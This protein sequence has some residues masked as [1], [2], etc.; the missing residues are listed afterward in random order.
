MLENF[1]SLHDEEI[2]LKA[3]KSKFL[4]IFSILIILFLFLGEIII[5]ISKPELKS[6]ADWLFYNYLNYPCFLFIEGICIYYLYTYLNNNLYLSSKKIIFTCNKKIKYINPADVKKWNIILNN[7]NIQTKY[8]EKYSVAG[9][10][11]A[12]EF[13]NKFKELYKELL[14]EE[15]KIK[16]TI[17]VWAAMTLGILISHIIT[18]YIERIPAPQYKTAE[19]TYIS[20]VERIIKSNWH[21]KKYDKSARI[22]LSFVTK[23]DGTITD[24][25]IKQS[26]GN[27]DLDNTTIDAVKKSSPLPALPETLNKNGFITIEFTFDYNVNNSI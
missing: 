8:N 3:E 13:S 16:T 5:I 1:E 14:P 19:T 25:M 17:W 7:I 21:T 26:S 27:P 24:I 15:Q 4:F 20:N 12:N 9:I 18:Y 2:I 10:K 11:N 6:Y 23:S 22:I